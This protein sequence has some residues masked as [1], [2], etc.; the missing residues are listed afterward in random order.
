MRSLLIAHNRSYQRRIL[1][2]SL[3]RCGYQ[4][5]QASSSAAALLHVSEH[6]PDALIVDAELHN[7]SARELCEKIVEQGRETA[8]LVFV[9]SQRLDARREAWWRALPGAILVDM[10][11]SARAVSMQIERHFGEPQDDS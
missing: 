3:E 2:L 1:Q 9:L 5:A 11:F 4:V 8:P 10:P 7:D 6:A